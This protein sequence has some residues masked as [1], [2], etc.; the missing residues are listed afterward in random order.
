MA[1]AGTHGRSL[2]DNCAVG[3]TDGLARLNLGHRVIREAPS[4]SYHSPA[5]LVSLALWGGSVYRLT[6]PPMHFMPPIFTS[7]FR[8]YENVSSFKLVF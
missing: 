5:L 2:M 8:T 6:R 4:N 1:A 3:G 7:V